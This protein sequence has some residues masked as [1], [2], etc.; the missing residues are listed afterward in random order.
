MNSLK[1]VVSVFVVGS[2]IALLPMCA[3]AEQSQETKDL[4]TEHRTAASDAQKKAV[5]HEDM[6]KKFVAGKGGAKMDMVGHCKYWADYYRKLA[7]Q[8]EK[9]AQ[10]LEHT[11]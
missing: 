10:D 8:E 3:W 5:F 6:E 11:N 2:A 7:S 1:K 9:A 4:I